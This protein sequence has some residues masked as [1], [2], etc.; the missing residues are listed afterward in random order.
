MNEK[1]KYG[2]DA[3]GVMRNLLVAGSVGVAIGLIA[4]LRS[5]TPWLAV[6]GWIPCA[7][8]VVI[9]FFGLLRLGYNLA[10]KVRTRKLL[11]NATP[12][13][14]S[15]LIRDIDTSALHKTKDK[16]KQKTASAEI[17]RVLK[18]G[19]YALIGDCLP[20]TTYAEAFAAE[21]LAV[22]QQHTAFALHCL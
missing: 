8:F 11:L 9:L 17:A 18:P 2:V 4:A 14:G 10:E 15:E 12:W 16:S 6:G 22:L 5:T 3:P 7:I 19:G 13:T 1:P 21:G 20:V